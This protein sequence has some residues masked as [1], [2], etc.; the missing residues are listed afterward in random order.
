MVELTPKEAIRYLERYTKSDFYTPQT[1]RAHLMAIEALMSKVDK[2]L[3]LHELRNMGG[4]KVYCLDLNTEVKVSAPKVGRITVS[5]S[6][7]GEWGSCPASGLTLYREKPVEHC[8]VD[9]G[10]KQFA[11]LVE[12]D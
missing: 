9:D 7:P 12:D 3:T 10:E 11:G 6:I 1:R 5:Y 8:A 2:P 4:Q